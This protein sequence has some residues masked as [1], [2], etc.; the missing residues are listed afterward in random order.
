MWELNNDERA[1]REEYISETLSNISFDE[2]FFELINRPEYEN[3]DKDMLE[4]VVE[5]KK[6]R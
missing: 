2:E 1:E 3:I 5:C 4:E 6:N